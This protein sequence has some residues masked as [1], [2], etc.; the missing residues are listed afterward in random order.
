[1][2]LRKYNSHLRCP[3]IH[4]SLVHYGLFSYCPKHHTNIMNLEGRFQRGMGYKDHKNMDVRLLLYNMFERGRWR[5]WKD[6]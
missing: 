1:M 5:Y 3:S 6:G 2:K 4:K